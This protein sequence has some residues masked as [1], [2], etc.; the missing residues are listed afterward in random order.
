V[1]FP[2]GA[3]VLV[4]AA[5]LLIAPC[6][7]PERVAA[8]TA[9][10]GGASHEWLSAA[11]VCL[12]AAVTMMGAAWRAAFGGSSGPVTTLDATARHAIGSM[13][14]SLGP[15]G[16]GA[17]ARIALFSRTLTGPDRLI[18]SGG[19]A[20]V[21]AVARFS[22]LGAIALTVL[23]VGGF[24]DPVV[25]FTVAVAVV[26]AVV[27]VATHP[28]S[29]S[30]RERIGRHAITPA[31]NSIHKVLG[32]TATSAM[33]R[34]GAC[35]CVAAGLGIHHPLRVGLVTI[36]SFSLVAVLP[37]VPGNVLGSG[38]AAIALHSSGLDSST[39]LSAGIA[40]QIFETSVNVAAGAVGALALSGCRYRRGR[41]HKSMR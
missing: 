4:V 25:V 6:F 28:R 39:A 8:A 36:I 24:L 32:W 9:R 14:S 29:R 30:A 16:V 26:G 22:A 33:A 5:S 41:L 15:A 13:V 12:F 18:R 37:L 40:Y 3:L 27:I 10:L 17:A 21:V 20:A 11:A 2:G 31:P 19:V 34:I 35:A 23:G 7:I 1:L 38:A